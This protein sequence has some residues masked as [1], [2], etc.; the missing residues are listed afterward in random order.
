MKSFIEFFEQQ[1]NDIFD[2]I[3]EEFLCEEEKAQVK[4]KQ[5]WQEFN[6]DKKHSTFSQDE[7]HKYYKKHVEPHINKA[8]KP[9]HRTLHLAKSHNAKV[10]S[11]RKPLDSFYN[12]VVERGK[13]STDIDDV[14][15][16]AI[17]TRDKRD[18][19]KVVDNLKKKGEV[20]KHEYKEFGDKKS[21]GGY[22]GVHHI[23]LKVNGVH[24]EV[25]VMPKKVWTYKKA[26]HKLYKKHR[27]N[28][29]KNNP[30]YQ[31]DMRKSKELMMRGNRFKKE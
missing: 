7:F 5:P 15:R 22:Y 2:L 1:F 9:F 20:V 13:D 18:T 31:Q 6:H 25:Q 12:K 16:G 30:E 3:Q 19:D 4:L 29:D 17:L 28:P 14:L 11:A 23:T 24:T 27:T 21:D 10:L 26:A 8:E